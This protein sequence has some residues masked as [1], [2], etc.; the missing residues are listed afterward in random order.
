[1]HSPRSFYYFLLFLL[2]L[3]FSTNAYADQCYS[4]DKIPAWNEGM[5]ALSV[6]M[7][8]N[9]WDDALQTAEK[10]NNICER[11]PMLN[12]AIGRI[13]KEKGN[14]SKALYYMQRATLFTEEFQ[15]KGK[16]LEQMWFDRYEAEHPEARPE[17]ID[18]RQNELNEIKQ[19]VEELNKEIIALKG[20]VKSASLG[21]KLETIEDAEAEKNHY[22]AGMWTGVASTGV[23]LILTGVGAG[24]IIANNNEPFELNKDN[25][26]PRVK[27]S[28]NTYWGLL[29]GGIAASVVG[30]IVTGCFGYYYTHTN[31]ADTDK[32]MVSFTV[33]GN[34]FGV[35]F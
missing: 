30:V 9:Q 6:Q 10:L 1:M 22:A 12:Y 27:G 25:G 29:G 19:R 11:S 31:S 23:G 35:Q 14:D 18:K 24:L 15:V 33:T 28:Y 2:T 5:T 3:A 26:R 20:D 21:S 16:T 32:N 4:I 34:G 17:V 7:R 8:N 13:Y